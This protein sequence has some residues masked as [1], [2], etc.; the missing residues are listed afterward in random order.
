MIFEFLL[1]LA[2]QCGRDS[3]ASGPQWSTSAWSRTGRE[4][5]V[6]CPVSAPRAHMDAE[7]PWQAPNGELQ[8][9]CFDTAA[10][11]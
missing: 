1:C 10:Y 8:R 7:D 9:V 2:I 6:W 5:K 3:N 4:A 11:A